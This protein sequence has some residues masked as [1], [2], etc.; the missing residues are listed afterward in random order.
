M[1]KQPCDAFSIHPTVHTPHQKHKDKKSHARINTHIHTNT[2]TLMHTH[3]RTH[4][5]THIHTQH[6]VFIWYRAFLAHKW[7]WHA[8]PL[9][10]S[11]MNEACL[12][13]WV[14]SYVSV[15]CLIWT[16]H[17]SYE[18]AMSHMNASCLIWMWW[19]HSHCVGPIHMSN[20]S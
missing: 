4:A 15:S 9:F 1:L 7:I 20:V 3:T 14:L 6:A 16:S 8:W 12:Y 19:W 11:H 18:W 2:H 13:E 5:C 17:V 10:G